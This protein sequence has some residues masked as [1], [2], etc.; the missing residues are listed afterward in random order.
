MSLSVS[1]AASTMTETDRLADRVDEWALAAGQP[2]SRAPHAAGA[3]SPTQPPAVSS[4]ARASLDSARAGRRARQLSTTS[5]GACQLHWHEL[6]SRLP[7]KGQ[8]CA[9]RLRSVA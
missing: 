2:V 5:H 1:L 8:Q 9:S 6:R 7:S 4:N 3:Q